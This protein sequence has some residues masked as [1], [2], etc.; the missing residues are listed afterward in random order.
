MTDITANVIVSMPSQLFT[1]ARSFKAVANGKI[2]IG[3]I[4]TDPVNPE[5]QIQVYVENE[6]G[7]HVPVAQPII[8]NAAGYPVYNGQIA[9]F[10]TV[11]GHSMAVYDAYGAQQ[12]YFPNVLKY[13][14]DQLRAQLLSPLDGLG[15]NLVNVKQPGMSSDRR[16]VHDKMIESISIADYIVNDSSITNAIINALS[17]NVGT[18]IIPPG[19]FVA[20]PSIEDV[21]G[22]FK[23]F[24]RCELRGRLT[25]NIPPGYS[26][27]TEKTIVNCIGAHN[28]TIKG[29]K[30]ETSITSLVSVAGSKKNY[31]VTISL[32]DASNVSVGDYIIIR[33][34]VSGTGAYHMHC[35]GWKVLSVSG[36]NVTVN[37]TCHLDNF[38]ESTLTG[39]SVSIIKSV[40]KYTGCD[41]FAVS[42]GDCINT[43]DGVA[44]VGDYS[45]A[46]SIGTIGAH[47]FTIATPDITIDEPDPSNKVFDMSGNLAIGP[48]VVISG[49]GEQGF[50]ASGRAGVVCN[51]IASSS[52]RKRGIYAEGAHIRGKFMVCSGNGE[53]GII[54]DIGGAIQA[55]GSVCS[56]NGL[57]GFWSFNNSELSAPNGVACG[58]STNGIEARALSKVNFE[59]GRSYL[60]ARNGVSASYGGNIAFTG[61]TSS[62]NVI[63]GIYSVYNATVAANNASSKNNRRYGVNCTDSMIVMTGSGDVSGNVAANYI[64]NGGGVIIDTEG[65]VIPVNAHPQRNLMLRNATTLSGCDISPSSI[66]DIT[67]S[68]KSSPS[69]DLSDR[70][71]FKADGTQHPS[72]DATQNLGRASNRYNVGYFA[73]GTQSSSD[74]RLKTAVRGMT[75]DEINAAMKIAEVLGFWSWI[76]D[77]SKRLHAG[78]TV[79]KVIAILEEN[80]LDW[81]KYGFIGYD[82]WDDE[83]EYVTEI[84]EF[85]NLVKNGEMK[86]IRAAGDLWQ[87]RDQELDRFIMRGLFERIRKLEESLYQR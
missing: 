29:I 11:Q 35:G 44:I 66:G 54:S 78:T 9:K 8:I 60:N 30:Y 71:V 52:N 63:D 86:L 46:E 4:D 79:Q 57:N 14:P 31:S 28:L 85:G 42:G 10:V 5:N 56:G 26:Y 16:T 17:S 20:N 6:D 68:L 48:D 23:L 21:S 47:G 81:K 12:F 32:S 73:G 53:D 41:G 83:F 22:L 27:F 33:H 7:S 38:P 24:S 51:F 50:V 45:V 72:G 1:M 64:D 82:A 36:A 43:I 2:Y 13:D 18:I 61:G 37:N 39:G 65:G 59:N 84:D 74:A 25:V 3:K 76:D 69:A 80:N 62:D 19:E 55:N 87:F 70:Y 77:E 58:N 49:W 75:A 67:I 34:D 40:L 15:D